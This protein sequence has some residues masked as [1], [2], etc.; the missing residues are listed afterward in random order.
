MSEG[1]EMC[2]FQIDIG[3]ESKYEEHFRRPPACHTQSPDFSFCD[4][5]ETS[6]DSVLIGQIQKSYSKVV[7]LMTGVLKISF[8]DNLY[9]ENKSECKIII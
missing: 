6:G 7:T 4:H 9:R 3:Y 5:K 1:E 2:N 8:N